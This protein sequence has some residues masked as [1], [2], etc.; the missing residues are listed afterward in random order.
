LL[1]DIEDDVVASENTVI[2][3]PAP[4]SARL[5]VV[6]AAMVPDLSRSKASAWIAAGHVRVADEV[7]TRSATGVREGGAVE[8]TVP[9][10]PTSD[11]VPEDIPLTFVHIDE[12]LAV[13]DKPPGLVVHPGAGHAT[14]T[15]VN[16]L[17]FHLGG[18]LS[19]EG[20]PERPGIVHRL[21]RGT[22]GLIAVARTDVAHRH[23][24]EQFAAHTARRRYLAICLGVPEETSGTIRSRIGRHP[25]DRLR[26]A[27]V[28]DG[29]RQAVTHWRV[30]VSG[31]GVSLIECQLETGRTHQIRVHL[32]E[33]GLPLLGDGLYRGGKSLPAPLAARLE[34]LLQDDRPMLHAWRLRLAHPADESPRTFAAP[35]PPDMLAVLR[36]LGFPDPDAAPPAERP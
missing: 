30:R 7:C 1:E 20:G 27:S 9:P 12:H 33:Q 8:I 14:G 11:A 5:D 32:S 3:G 26:F 34:G 28:D 23:L 35:V 16:A 36:A 24:A 15:M 21:D 13:V 10:P 25:T 31:R 22:S 29:G 18:G 17:R 6:V 19:G 2:A 4:L